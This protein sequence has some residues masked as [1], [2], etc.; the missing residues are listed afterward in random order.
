MKPELKLTL[1]TDYICPFCYIGDL[2]LNRLREDYDILVNFRFIEIHPDTPLDGAAVETLNYSTEK[3]TEM[4]DGLAEMA[5]EEQVEFASHRHLAN[6]H[7]ALLLAEA[8][9]QAG[10]EAFYQL[11]T[12]MYEACFVHGRSIGQEIVL[13]ELAHESGLDDEFIDQAWNSADNEKV[14]QQNMTI[15]VQAGVTGTPTFFIGERRLVGAV[16]LELLRS[17]ASEAIGRQSA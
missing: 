6:S 1:F 8:A 11:H 17:A 3:W 7:R 14:L 10:P 4:M 9:K 2:R 15:A 12:K 5:R 13:R 16:S